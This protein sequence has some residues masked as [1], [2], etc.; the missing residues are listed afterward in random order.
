LLF[1]HGEASRWAGLAQLAS[2]PPLPAGLR[3]RPADNWRPL[4]AIA[5]AI[6]GEWPELARAAAV[7]LSRNRSDE[8]PGVVLLADIRRV[9][10]RRQIDRVPSADMVSDL[11]AIEDGLWAEWRGPTDDEHPRKLT[12]GELARLLRPFGIRP[13]T[14]W[15]LPRTRS[16]QGYYRRQFEASWAAYCPEAN[17]PTQSSKIRWLN[18]K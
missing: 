5:D 10:D 14:V 16:A 15:P 4:I 13:R 8:D 11:V 17:T 3:N 6:G 18:R 7:A 1:V 9:F 2:D 12:Q